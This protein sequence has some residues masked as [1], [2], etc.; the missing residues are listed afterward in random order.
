MNYHTVKTKA[1]GIMGKS[2]E[3]MGIWLFKPKYV[4]IVTIF[5]RFRYIYIKINKK[6]INFLG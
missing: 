3:I 1:V 6:K 4:S 2:D 5:L